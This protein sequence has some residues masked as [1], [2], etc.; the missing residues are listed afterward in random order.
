MK[1][2]WMHEKTVFWTKLPAQRNEKINSDEQHAIF[3]YELQRALRLTAGFSKM[4][5]EL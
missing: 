4:Y 2:R 1:E 5:C 3:A